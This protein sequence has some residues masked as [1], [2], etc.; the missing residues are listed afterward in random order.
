[1]LTSKTIAIGRIVIVAAV[2]LFVGLGSN[3]G[4]AA[5]DFM[6]KSLQDLIAGAKK[7]KEL[8]AQWS[9]RSLQGSKGFTAIVNAMNKRWGLNI[10][11]KFTPGPNMQ[12]MATKLAREMKAG[13]PASSDVYWGNAQAILQV[14]DL[15]L[16]LGL[17]WLKLLERPLLKEEGFDPVAPGSVAL[18][19]A[20][21]LVGVTYNSDLVKGDD[22]P[23]TLADT[24]NPKW[25]GKIAST[26]Y[27]AGMREFSMPKLLGKEAMIEFTKKLSKQ[28]G[29]LIRCGS[30]DRITS[31]EFVMQVMSCG[32]QYVNQAART[33]VPLGY[34]VL[35]DATIS[36]TRYGAVPKHSASP[37]AAALFVLYL[38]TPEGQKW[39]WEANG[40]DFHLYPESHE[41][42]VLDKARAAGAKVGINAPQWLASYPEYP[43][44]QKEL[45]AILRTAKK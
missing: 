25:K 14:S 44:V 23:K 40:F 34:A 15:K 16:M 18:A 4:F 33:G 24:L 43:K 32:D 41:K 30:T 27:A 6:S 17:N 5:E 3:T 21:T 37:N 28:V 11:P 22:I 8:K 26:P 29:G 45:E 20:S 39:M 36:H 1:M 9:S 12:G 2:A 35:N 19:S 10:A 13:Q 31:G 38:H 7:E 42:K